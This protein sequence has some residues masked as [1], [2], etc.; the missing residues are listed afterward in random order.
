MFRRILCITGL[1]VLSAAVNVSDAQG[2][3]I[4]FDLPPTGFF[5]LV[6]QDFPDFP[7]FNAYLVNDIDVPA[8]GWCIDEVRIYVSNG[9]PGQGFSSWVGGV[10][11]GTINVF[12]DDGALDS[13]NPAL[14]TPVV[15]ACEDFGTD[16]LSV[17]ASGL[18]LELSPGTYWIG[19]CPEATFA[20]YQQEFTWGIGD[21][22]I[23]GA[24]TE[25]RNPGGG[26][27]VGTNW[28]PAG[29]LL[30]GDNWDMAIQITGDVGAC[31]AGG[32]TFP[33]DSYNAFRGVLVSGDLSSVLTSD[34]IDLCFNPGIT[35][36]PSEAPVTLDFVGTS[37]N[38]TPSSISI[39]I[40][41]SAN[42]VGLGLTFRM[43]K[44]TGTPGWQTVGTAG[45]SN[46]VD[47]VRTFNGVP[48]DH[49]QG[50]TGEVR[51]R[52]EVRKTGFVFLFPWTDCIDQ[53]FWTQ[54]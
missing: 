34:N 5:R 20:D 38:D 26:F 41:S 40:E 30:I 15:V 43:W 3:G 18:G 7:S 49:V 6:N 2:P 51:V 28:E 54:N 31:G 29:M 16:V 11:V 33:P 4:L 8:Q 1:V 48:A 36:F 22:L 17:T 27:G 44:F 42:T 10:T 25:F 21:G 35:L 19:L 9:N 32:G 47:T 23:D 39:T 53:V 24:A 12:E 13:E 37:P 45:Q 14:G 50:G 52:Y 46:N